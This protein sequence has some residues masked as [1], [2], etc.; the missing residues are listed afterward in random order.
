MEQA[1]VHE[2][3]GKEGEI[4]WQYHAL[5]PGHQSGNQCD[6]LD[7]GTEPLLAL[8]DQYKRLVEKDQYVYCHNC[9]SHG[10]KAA[11]RHNLLCSHRREHLFSTPLFYI[12][13]LS[14]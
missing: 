13:W 11:A 2:H 5:S 1:G 6:R 12:I 8:G 3:G 10:R 14:R 7:E 9:R 4:E